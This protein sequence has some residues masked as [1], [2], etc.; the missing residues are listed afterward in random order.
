M[1]AKVPLMNIIFVLIPIAILFVIIAG[2]SSSGP[3]APSSLKIS[4][5]KVPTSCLTKNNPPANPQSL[6]TMTHNLDLAGALLVGL[7][8]SAH[9]IGMCGGVSAALSMAIPAN[10]QHFWDGS[11]ICSTTTSAGS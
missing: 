7:A 1:N 11:P 5:G 9:C 4:T 8:G 2:S 6:L 10:K 3:F